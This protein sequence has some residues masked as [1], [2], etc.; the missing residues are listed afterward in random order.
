MGGLQFCLTSG[1]MMFSRT[2]VLLHFCD[3]ALPATVWASS[4]DWLPLWLRDG[5]QQQAG[6]QVACSHPLGEK[7]TSWA[8]LQNKKKSSKSL[9]Q[10]SPCPELGHMLIPQPVPGKE[11]GASQVRPPGAEGGTRFSGAPWYASY[12]PKW[13]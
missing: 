9:W 13:K 3:S 12:R 5:C 11:D 2:H 8:S 1:L 7:V 6:L 10:E 4:Y